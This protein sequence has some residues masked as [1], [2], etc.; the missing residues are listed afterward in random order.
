[1]NSEH[2]DKCK[3]DDMGV[4]LN[5]NYAV[6]WDK[7]GGNSAD[8]C[9]ESYRGN[10]PFSEPETLAVR[11]FLRSHHKEVKFAYNFHSYGNM[12]LWPYNG[13]TPNNLK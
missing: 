4:D 11:D 1:M 9:E 3:G 13:M 6:F 8:P 7:P 12:Y 2:A 5:R 10:H